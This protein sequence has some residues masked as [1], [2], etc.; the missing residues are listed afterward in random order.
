MFSDILI[1]ADFD[2]TMTA[3]DGSIP[4]RNLEAVRF[5][6]ENGGAFTINTGRS[7][8]MCET[9]IQR[10]PMNAPLL[11]YNGGAA[12]DIEKKA[13]VFC[14]EL[15]LP[16]GRTMA[17]VEEMFP[18]LVCELE[19]LYGHYIFKENPVWNDFV[20]ALR[21][22]VRRAEPDEDLGPFLKFCVLG[23]MADNDPAGLYRGS[24]EESR[25]FD[26]VEAA[27]RAEFGD[28]ADIGRPAPRIVDVYSKGVSKLSAARRLQKMLG[29]KL[30]VCIGD[31]G[32]DISMLDG[33]DYAWCPGDA[34]VRD[35]YETVCTSAEGAV[36]DV[37]FQKLPAILG[38]KA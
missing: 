27:I 13:L 7:L 22:P 2:N 30:L 26:K 18:E 34:W 5:F 25:Y 1:T 35:R 38:K 10:V 17:R 12:F 11:V 29:R 21:C 23:P 3:R 33:A 31:G 15:P 20:S 8:P 36:A 4:L 9:V 37:I 14:Q 24:R 19:G 6:M 32:N 28:A 16:M